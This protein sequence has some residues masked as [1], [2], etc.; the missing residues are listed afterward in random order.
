MMKTVKNSA[1][2]GASMISQHKSGPISGLWLTLG[3]FLALIQTVPAFAQTGEERPGE[4]PRVEKIK[5]GPHPLYTRVLI[6][7]NKPIPYEIKPDFQQKK[8]TVILRSTGVSPTVRSRSYKDRNLSQIDVKTLGDSIHITLRLKQENT[9]FFHFMHP[10]IPRIILDLKGKD[11]PIIKAQTRSRPEPRAAKREAPKE[12]PLITP[13]KD[14]TDGAKK[15]GRKTEKL[16]TKITNLP[17]EKLQEIMQADL[18]EKFRGG[19]D[20]FQNALKEYQKNNYPEAVALFDKFERK[21]PESKYLEEILYLEA[22]ARFRIAVKEPR[23]VYEDALQAY[24]YAARK[25]PKSK[26]LDHT[27]HKLAVLYDEL[28]YTLEAKAAYRQGL[29]RNR[30]SIYNQARKNGLASLLVKEGKY[31]EAY[32][33]FQKTLKTNPKDSAAQSAYFEIANYYFDQKDYPRALE[34]YEEAARRWPLELAERPRVN[35]NM[36][37]IYFSQKKYGNARKHYFNLINLTPKTGKA[38]QALNRIG[39][40]YLLEGKHL[41]ALYVFDESAKKRPASP[42]TQ[43]AKIRMADI[44]VLNPNLKTPDVIFD[45]SP[46]Y[47][48]LKTYE[49]VIREAQNVETLAEATLSRGIAYLRGQNYLLAIEAFKKLVPLGPESRIFK[50][51]RKFIK[52][53]LIFLVDRYAK[54]G[55]A[56]PILYAYSDFVSLSVGTIDDLKT[57]LQIGEAYQSIGMFPEALNMYERVKELDVR[58]L[59]S[60]RILL[61]LGQ[62]HLEKKNYSE[63]ELVARSFLKNYP[64]SKRLPEIMKLLGG[65]FKGQ[66]KYEEALIIYRDLLSRGPKYQT[67]AHYLMGA[68]Y[69]AMKD[70]RK[71]IAAYRKTID[72]FDRKTRIIPNYIRAAFY[73]LGSALFQNGQY[74]EA[75]DALSAAMQLFPEHPRREWSEY[76]LAQSYKQLNKTPEEKKQLEKML[77]QEAGDDLLKKAAAARLRVLDWEKQFKENL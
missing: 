25:F 22:E 45:V 6:D 11:A 71:E 75:T 24:K 48:P 8:V 9:R 12:K 1:L 27:L 49:S 28:G 3:L 33:A 41:N 60:D 39:D 42:H 10:K 70:T 47:Q 69:E 56:L 38:G 30:R 67:E 7:L 64:L 50:E 26:F 13:R 57:L 36:G 16:P 72:T 21:Y 53:A 5:I 54:Q 55:G 32:L 34:I 74:A 43:Y 20:D 44:G 15:T 31:R 40:S 68:V 35:F 14:K 17:Q 51:A 19:W 76:L 52:Q 2:I 46:Y 4:N 58:N 73:K 18:D 77:E 65:S 66:G 23:P 29:K 61:N 37:E 59:Y 63:A 62:I